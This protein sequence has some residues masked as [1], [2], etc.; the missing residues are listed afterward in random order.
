MIFSS[1]S[2]NRVRKFPIN[3]HIFD[4]KLSVHNYEHTIHSILYY[5]FVGVEA[6]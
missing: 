2:I 4:S 3:N 5:T 6:D 1:Q